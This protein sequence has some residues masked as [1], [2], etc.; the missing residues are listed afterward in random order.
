MP[1]ILHITSH[2]GGGVGKA[3]TDQAIY[4]KKK[5]NQYEE[6]FISLEAPGKGSVPNR[7]ASLG[8]R[9]DTVTDPGEVLSRIKEADIVQL[10]WW[11]HPVMA[12]ILNTHEFKARLLVWC[13]TSGV[14]HPKIPKQWIRTPHCFLFTSIASEVAHGIHDGYWTDHVYSVGELDT[15]WFIE[16]S[17]KPPVFGYLGS[18]S[19]SKIHPGFGQFLDT[20]S[21][22]HFRVNL[23]GE[24][25]AGSDLLAHPKVSYRGFTNEPAS[26]LAELDVLTYLLNPLHYGTTENALLEAMSR[27]VVPIVIGNACEAS[28]VGKEDG[29]IIDSPAGLRE[30]VRFLTDFPKDRLR[31]SQNASES[32]RCRFSVDSSVAKMNAFYD[33]LMHY[34]KWDFDLSEVFGKTPFDWYDSCAYHGSLKA[35]VLRETHKSSPAHF[36]R[37]FPDDMALRESVRRIKDA[38]NS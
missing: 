37:Y 5:S 17:E 33:Q 38:N 30:A 25:P 21:D 31:M 35:H 13:H 10:E 29:I 4:R 19:R 11:N 18:L 36:L 22:A 8:F 32:V 27:G 9:V 7:L 28:I 6:S 12:G 15:F 34:D 16:R 14:G 2:L 1:K 20:V 23:W 24:M 3:L 26:V